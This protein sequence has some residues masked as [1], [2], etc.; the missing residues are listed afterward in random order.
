MILDYID[1]INTYKALIPEADEI[2]RFIADNQDTPVGRYPLANDNYVMIQEGA[3]K[4]PA[5][6][7]F[8]SHA[9]YLDF[10][11]I[12]AG[13]EAIEWTDIRNLEESARDEAK[14]KINYT[15]AGQ[16]YQLKPGMFYLLYPSDG[17]KACLTMGEPGSYRKFVFKLK[18]KAE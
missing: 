6:G 1:N 5:E 12:A 18:I 13:D 2:Q 7:K 16:L 3:L 10:Q 15:G 14:D 11:Y 4:A 9:Q 8:E 17:H